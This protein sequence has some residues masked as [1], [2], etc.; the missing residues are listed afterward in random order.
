ML[1]TMFLN[2]FSRVPRVEQY[3][4]NVRC[5][6]YTNVNV[7][8]SRSADIPS[9]KKCLKLHTTN[10]RSFM[11]YSRSWLCVQVSLGAY[12]SENYELEDNIKSKA[13]KELSVK[14]TSL[15]LD[16]VLKA[17]LQMSRNKIE[18]AFYENR[19]KVNGRK[20]TKKSAQV[21]EGDALDVAVADGRQ[22][23]FERVARVELL[24]VSEEPEGFAIKFLKYRTLA[25][26]AAPDERR[27]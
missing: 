19:I 4:K 6:C 7:L 21:A 9:I 25:E 8:N 2:Y 13:F 3:M 24:Q 18:T 14:V 17:T 5:L 16:I 1:M 26:D 23:Q 20:V 22:G 15:R 10:R 12:N 27:R 11:N